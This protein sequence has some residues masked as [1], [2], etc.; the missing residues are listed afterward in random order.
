M[1]CR[2]SAVRIRLAPFR[3]TPCAA[4]GLFVAGEVAGRPGG[5]EKRK[6]KRKIN[7]PQWI[8]IGMLG[9]SGEGARDGIAV[10]LPLTDPRQ[11]PREARELTAQHP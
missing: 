7:R 4:R 8:L 2:G 10:L 5:A 6:M 1:A 9:C 11:K 3:Q